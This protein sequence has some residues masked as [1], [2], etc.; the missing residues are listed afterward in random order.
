[1]SARGLALINPESGA[2]N[3]N[4]GLLRRV[5][6]HEALRDVELRL[7][8]SPSEISDAAQEGRDSQRPFVVAG[9][10][11]GTLHAAVNGLL[12]GAGAGRDEL[13]LFALL[14]LGTAND[15]ARSL[16]VHDL[17]AALDAIVAARRLLESARMDEGTQAGGDTRIDAMDVLKVELDDREPE[18]VTNVCVAGF[19]G[20][21][22]QAVTPEL[23][24]RWGHLSYLRGGLTVFEPEGYRAQMSI[25]DEPLA[26][27]HFLNV[28]AA[29]GRY[30]G[31]GIPFAPEARVDD[32]RV[33][34]VIIGP[35]GLADVATLAPMVMNGSHAEHDAVTIRAARRLRLVCEEGLDYSLD[36]DAWTARQAVVEVVPGALRAVMREVD[37]DG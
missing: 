10:G 21:V 22:Q 32:A 29:N 24:E 3:E 33:D 31:G 2:L 23:K 13:P 34:I 19:G 35:I 11:D 14:P 17:D 5:R 12:R 9:G 1:M 15:F 27:V 26:E 6:E 30:S 28:A 25:D 7:V 4:E 36:G 20:E 37:L 8:T 16:G 18:F